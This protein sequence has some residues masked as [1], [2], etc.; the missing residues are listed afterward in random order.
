MKK[1]NKAIDEVRRGEAA[2]AGAGRLRA[3][4]EAF[5]VVPVEAAG[6]PDG[7]ADGEAGGVA[8]VQPAE[9][10]ELPAAGGL[11]AVL[12]VRQPRLGGEVPGPVVYADPAEPD[13]ADEEDRSQLAGASGLDPQLVP[14]SGH[15]FGRHGRGAEQQSET[16]YE[17]SVWLSHLRS[18]RN[19][20]ISHTW[21]PPRARI[22]PRI[23][24][25]RQ[26][27]WSA[28]IYRRFLYHG[29]TPAEAAPSA[30][31]TN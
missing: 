29:S 30:T 18:H 26:F 25:R 2:P 27:F 7:E 23:L 13:R 12:G 4:A 31:R 28:A 8:A 11:P 22:H 1:M 21:R 3:G 10:P 14:R 17:K 19:R 6:E 15:H 5:A 16:D 9:R 24:L 20:V